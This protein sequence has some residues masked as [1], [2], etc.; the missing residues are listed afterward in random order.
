MGLFDAIGGLLGMGGGQSGT[1]IAAPTAANLTATTNG[2]QIGNAYSGT[3]NS[4]QSQQALLQALQQQNGLENQNQVYGQLQGVANGTGPNPAQA[5]LNQATGANVANQAALMAGQ[6]GAGANAG[7]IA[8]QAAQQGANTQQ[9]AIGQGASLQAQQSLGALGQAGA[10]AN[11]QAGQQIGQTNANVA[12]Q[13]QE[14]QNLLNAG[15]QLNNSAV[16]SQNNINSV[17]GSLANTGLQNQ[18]SGI[19]G[20]SGG[21]GSLGAASGLLGSGAQA[22]QTAGVLFSKGG[23]VGGPK[24]FAGKHLAMAKGGK[25]QDIV[26]SPGEKILDP[27][28]AKT[29][30]QDKSKAPQIMAQAKKVP[31]KAL[32]KGDS[33]KND[34]VPAKAAA[35]SVVVPRT[36]ANMAPD[37][38]RFIEA[39]LS[40]KGK[41]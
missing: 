27:M 2:A 39:A 17:N 26:V 30:A 25:V 19:G 12:G 18:A 14:Q 38:A 37:A 34:I 16:S 23:E 28:Q 5:M 3:Q 31:G 1:G 7:L 32:V 40:K 41:K 21:L 8:R 13:T 4:L 11:T 6:R 20:L 29:V 15:A 9:Q 36:K 10:L 22:A 33:K 35:G 24:S